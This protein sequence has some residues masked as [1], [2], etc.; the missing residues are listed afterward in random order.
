MNRWLVVVALLACDRPK[1]PPPPAPRVSACARVSDHLVSL[2]SG[3]AKHPPEAT[4]SLRRVIE[5]RC[6]RDAWTE[7]TNQ[8]LLSLTSLSDGDRCQALMTRAQVEA[9]HR[10]TEAATAELRGQ[11]SEEPPGEQPPGEQPRGE[12]P[13]GEQPPGKQPPG[14]QKRPG[15]PAADTQPGGSAR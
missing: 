9:F 8:C 11:F 3:A 12:Q 13:P 5:Q 15:S 1:P 14:E 10:D 2:M 6:D 7:Q 4:D